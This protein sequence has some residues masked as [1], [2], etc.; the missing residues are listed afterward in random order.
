MQKIAELMRR[1]A[2]ALLTAGTVT[3]VLGWKNGENAYDPAPTFF[4]QVSAVKDLVY[5]EF[6]GS[7]LSKLLVGATKRGEKVAVFLKPCDTYSLNQLLKENRVDR[8]L[9]TV[10]G[11]PCSGMVDINKIRSAGA[12]GI[13]SI[14]ARAG[15]SNVTLL[16]TTVYGSKE[17][18]K[19]EVLL[20]KCLACKGSDY[21]V[22]DKTLGSP[23]EVKHAPFAP[24][25]EVEALE[26]LAPAE[27]FAFWQEEL[28]KCIRCNACREVCPLCSCEQCIFDNPKSPLAAKANT[29]TAEEQVFHIIRAYHVAGRCTDCGE[30][31][32]VCPQGIRLELLNRK[33]IKDINEF[34]GEYQAGADATSKGP[35][36]DFELTDVEAT[37]VAERGHK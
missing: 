37:V 34:Y 28:S 16:I 23:M 27:R 12:K 35:L 30:C 9:V 15:E 31:S 21:M 5:N 22:S 3:A 13:K 8:T 26:K 20:K 2:E 10:I 17:V 19:A 1:E 7:N 4:T 29:T 6:C 11:I 36:T 18:D 32:R 33:F 14:E 25:A 24:Y